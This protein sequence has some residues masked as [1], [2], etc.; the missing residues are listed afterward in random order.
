MNSNRK[1]QNHDDS[2]SL[3][4]NINIIN[5]RT[6][7]S[8]VTHFWVPK[9]G[10]RPTHFSLFAA[11]RQKRKLL[12]FYLSMR[13]HGTFNKNKRTQQIQNLPPTTL[14]TKMTPPPARTPLESAGMNQSIMIPG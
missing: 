7:I 2:D 5:I 12:Q 4:R 8:H 6:S 3:S 1:R 13:I 9:L 11:R 14:R 10:G